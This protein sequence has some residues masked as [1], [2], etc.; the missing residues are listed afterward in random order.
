MA[1]TANKF[2]LIYSVKRRDTLKQNRG[3]GRGA[4]DASSDSILE[5][6]NLINYC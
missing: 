2:R 6:K 1:C 3:E 5:I 4:L